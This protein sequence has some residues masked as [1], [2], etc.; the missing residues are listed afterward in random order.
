M[1]IITIFKYPGELIE[2]RFSFSDL[3]SEKIQQLTWSVV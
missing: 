3:R 2:N 1:V